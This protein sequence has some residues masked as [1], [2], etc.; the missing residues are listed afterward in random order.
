M[1]VCRPNTDE[2]LLLYVSI[3]DK[4]K[5]KKKTERGERASKY[6]LNILQCRL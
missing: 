1:H 3:R 4:L 6:K 2:C 5:N